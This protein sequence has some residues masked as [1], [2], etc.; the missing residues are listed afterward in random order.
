MTAAT[1]SIRN[2]TKSFGSVVGLD[3]VDVEVTSGEVS[4]VPRV[5]RTVLPE[6]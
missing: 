4:H 3:G 2:A 6:C 5:L 1:L